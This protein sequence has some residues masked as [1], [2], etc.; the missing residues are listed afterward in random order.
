MEEG[1]KQQPLLCPEGW[2]GPPGSLELTQL[3]A[4]IAE[5]EPRPLVSSDP[6]VLQL[7]V[8]GQVCV[9]LLGQTLLQVVESPAWDAL[10]LWISVCPYSV[11]FG[12]SFIPSEWPE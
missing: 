6:S 2:R 10:S 9:R 8:G 1:L 3:L 5:A 7:R 12:S 11:L 4:D